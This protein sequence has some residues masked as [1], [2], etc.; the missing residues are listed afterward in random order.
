MVVSLR[1]GMP[2]PLRSV[3]RQTV[4]Q[5]TMHFPLT[6]PSFPV[7]TVDLL[8]HPRR[9][10]VRNDSVDGDDGEDI[11]YLYQSTTLGN[12]RAMATFESST[13]GLD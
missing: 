12:E 5:A 9:K 6:N 2:R 7:H 1:S 4:G 8:N 10:T 11:F 3:G 13:D